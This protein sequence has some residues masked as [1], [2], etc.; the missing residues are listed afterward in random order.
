MQLNLA[1]EMRDSNTEALEGDIIDNFTVPVSVSSVI[2][3]Q[4]ITG[5]YQLATIT[6]GYLMKSINYGSQLL[7]NTPYC[8][9][10]IELFDK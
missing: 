9:R 5:S 1:I 3:P 6:I 8:W 2:Q 10:Y 7:P 4:I